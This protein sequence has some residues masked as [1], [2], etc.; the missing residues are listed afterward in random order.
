MVAPFNQHYHLSSETPASSTRVNSI[1]LFDPALAHQ[2]DFADVF[3]L[4]NLQS[5]TGDESSHLLLGAEAGERICGATIC[6]VRLKR[7]GFA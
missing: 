5:L 7:C 1:N 6:E 4:S 3:A 2:S